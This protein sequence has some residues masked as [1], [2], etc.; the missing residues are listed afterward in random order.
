MN[1][2]P[3]SRRKRGMPPNPGIKPRRNSGNPKPRHLVRHN[4]VAD[5]SKFQPAAHAQPVHR[6]DGYERRGIQRVHHR[7]D[8]LQERACARHA[9]FHR[10]RQCSFIQLF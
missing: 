6:G 8:A 10:Q 9:F 3:T 2:L 7:M 5:Q 1:P 4:Q